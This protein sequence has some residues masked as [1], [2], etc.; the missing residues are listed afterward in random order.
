MGSKGGGRS[1]PSRRGWAGPR[2][3]RDGRRPR[4]D[5]I[6]LCGELPSSTPVIWCISKSGQVPLRNEVDKGSA[7]HESQPGHAELRMRSGPSA[8]YVWDQGSGNKAT[9]RSGGKSAG[10]RAIDG[11]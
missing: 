10:S 8:L 1:D 7:L 4:S 11:Q 9:H 6:V 3:A 2:E 5:A